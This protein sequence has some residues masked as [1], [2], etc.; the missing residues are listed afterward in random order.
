MTISAHFRL[1]NVHCRSPESAS[2]STLGTKL[3]REHEQTHVGCYAQ[4]CEDRHH[5]PAR[6]ELLAVQS[7]LAHFGEELLVSFMPAEQT[8]KENTRSVHGEQGADGIELR[9][10]DLQHDEREA[11]LPDRGADVRSFERPLCGPNLD[12]LTAGQNY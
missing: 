2:I 7:V 11:E 3:E 6:S 12:Q 8:R 1:E 5:I 9:S 4:R 10:E